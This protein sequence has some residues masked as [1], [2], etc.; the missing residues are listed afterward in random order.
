MH[1]S[2]QLLFLQSDENLRVGERVMI[3]VTDRK[4]VL[5]NFIFGTQFSFIKGCWLYVKSLFTADRRVGFTIWICKQ[6]CE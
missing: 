6:K 2:F 3:N 4:R 5:A 1:I